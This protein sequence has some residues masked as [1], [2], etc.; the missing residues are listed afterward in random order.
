MEV[1]NWLNSNSGAIIAL[2]TIVLVCI[3]G[4]YAWVTKKILEENRQMRIDAQKPNIGI[5]LRAVN[6]SGNIFAQLY[7]ENIGS[8]P[9][10]DVKFP[11]VPAFRLNAWASFPDIP[12][13]RYGIGYLAPGKERTECLGTKSQLNLDE[14]KHTITVTYQDSRKKEYKKCFPLDFRSLWGE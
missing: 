14:L 3:T 11:E 12:F 6:K 9:A 2:A 4:Y 7:V 1:I 5:H 8:G 10:R 13:L